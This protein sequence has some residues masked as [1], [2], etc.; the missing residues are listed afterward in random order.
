M[1]TA[2]HGNHH[3]LT[4]DEPVHAPRREISRQT[5]KHCIEEYKQ[6]VDCSPHGKVSNANRNTAIPVSPFLALPAELRNRIYDYILLDSLDVFAE[7]AHLPPLLHTC[8][9]ISSEYAG[10]FYA[11]SLIKLDSYYHATDSWAAVSDAR[12]KRRILERATFADLW[13]FWSLASARRYCQRG[14]WNRENVLR[15][16]VT[17]WTGAAWR[18]WQWTVLQE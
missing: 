9:Q 8:R 14:C 18:R 17:V 12:G 16:I 15:G 4:R 11:T 3:P 7:T 13:D 6:S 10:I 5:D 1:T 2:Q